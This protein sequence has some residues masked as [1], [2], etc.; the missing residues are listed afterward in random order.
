MTG[1]SS[2]FMVC[3]YVFC[4]EKVSVPH[5]NDAISGP[6]IRPNVRRD[7]RWNVD[8]LETF[9]CRL[10]SSTITLRQARHYSDAIRNDS[11]HDHAPLCL[12]GPS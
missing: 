3:S 5:A 2:I 6:A 10:S 11:N 1:G 8:F 4:L 12:T 7:I 9:H